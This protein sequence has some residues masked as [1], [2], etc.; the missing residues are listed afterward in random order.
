MG[1]TRLFALCVGQGLE[2]FEEASSYVREASHMDKTRAGTD[3]LVGLIA[4][5]LQIPAATLN[6]S[7]GDL[8]AAAR[9]I[10]EEDDPLMFGTGDPDPHP[11]QRTRRFIAVQ[12]L[13]AG[14][15][16]AHVA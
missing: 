7:V 14:L 2:R 15:I 13:D 16:D 9:V 8:A 10:I 3:P 11:V 6:E 1:R 4:V 5:T 12:H